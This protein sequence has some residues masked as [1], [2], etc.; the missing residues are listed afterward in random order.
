MTQYEKEVE[1]QRMKLAAE[2]WRKGV[3]S[4][5]VHKLKSMWY[6]TRPQDTDEHNVT[7]VHYNDD[8]IIRTLYDGTKII[9]Q[10]GVEGKELLDRFMR[11]N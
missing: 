1:L 10:D 6:E 7:D 3:R 9:L 4:I 11:Y 2:E 5:H 8:S